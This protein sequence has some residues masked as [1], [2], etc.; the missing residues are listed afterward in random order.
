MLVVVDAGNTR[1]K[2]GAFRGDRLVATE[3]TEGGAPAGGGGAGGAGDAGSRAPLADGLVPFPHVAAADE[4]VVVCSAPAVL[5]VVLAALPGRPR[6]LGDELLAAVAGSYDDPAE[7]GVDRLA[8][9]YGAQDAVGGGPVVVVDAGTCTTVDAIDADGRFVAIAIAA[10]VRAARVGLRH[11]APH[12][13]PVALDGPPE[14]P[15]R[16]TDDALRNG[17]LLGGAG[18]VDRLVRA[19]RSVVG[20]APLVLTGGAA[21]TLLP[22]L[23]GAGELAPHAVLHGARR[24]HLEVPL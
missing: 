12:L 23:A 10:G 14:V 20:D 9:A 4:I 22:L 19:A 5:P 6:V 18:S 24:L 1:V 17:V 2:F 8:A 15:A 21:P 13:P 16:G 7:L 11:A 3:E